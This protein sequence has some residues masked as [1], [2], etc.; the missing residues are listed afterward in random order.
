MSPS[1]DIV[2][3]DGILAVVAGSDTTATTLSNIFFSL[4]SYP[5]TYRRLQAEVDR[6][7]PRGEDALDP[8]YYVHMSYLEAIMWVESFFES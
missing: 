4:L 5:E 7:Y 8:R 3:A 2:L 1:R 6:Y